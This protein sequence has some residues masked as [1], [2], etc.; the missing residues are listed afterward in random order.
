MWHSAATP[1]PLRPRGT[2]RLDSR[3]F[4]QYAVGHDKLINELLIREVE[5][6]GELNGIESPETR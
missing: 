3:H 6:D 2:R 5:G 4:R 1:A